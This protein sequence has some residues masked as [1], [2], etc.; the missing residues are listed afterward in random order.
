M[1]C[2]VDISGLLFANS[3]THRNLSVG[4]QPTGGVYGT[5]KSL[6][7]IKDEFSCPII[8]V[9]DGRS[10]RKDESEEYKANR[11]VNQEAK[12]LKE[13]VHAQTGI[14]KQFVDQM[15]FIQMQASNME[16]DD[17][18]ALVVRRYKGDINL[19][20]RDGDW[21]QLVNRPGIK[22]INVIQSREEYDF[23]SAKVKMKFNTVEQFVQAKALMG[24]VGDNVKSV[25]GIGLAGA[26]VIMR[27]FG[28]VEKFIQDYKEGREYSWSKKFKDFLD[29]EEKQ[30]RFSDNMLLVDLNDERIPN[31][32]DLKT[33]KD[34][35]NMEAFLDLCERYSFVSLIP[36]AERIR[37]ILER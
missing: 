21:L 2:V 11:G 28:S 35:I 33:K 3:Y 20:T 23:Y 24:D 30:K 13:K 8:V 18:A 4:D 25:G 15:G 32:V 5:I 6:I 17:L 7:E 37:T 26:K 31:P 19:V 27:D 36:Q 1:L 16:A 29:S 14:L 34:A 9:W 22:W 12:E 10:W